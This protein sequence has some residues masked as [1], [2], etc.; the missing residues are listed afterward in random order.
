MYKSGQTQVVSIVT[1]GMKSEEQIL[2]GLDEEDSKKIYASIQF[3]I[4]Q[5]RR[6]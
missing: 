5:C 2:D 4:I 1:L 3:P 6:G